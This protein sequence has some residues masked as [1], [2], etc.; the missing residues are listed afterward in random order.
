[1]GLSPWIRW[2]ISVS[3]STSETSVS[4]V[5]MTGARII[6]PHEIIPRL[7]RRRMGIFKASKD[8]ENQSILS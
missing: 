7:Y 8:G 4:V 2:A 3:N 6:Q 5:K 1:M